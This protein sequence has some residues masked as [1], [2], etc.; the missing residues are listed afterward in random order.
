MAHRAPDGSGMREVWPGFFLGMGRLAIVDR[1]AKNVSPYSF[2]TKTI[3]FNGEIYNH[4]ALRSEL[5]KDFSFETRTDT[6]VFL[7]G[8]VAWGPRVL[9]RVNGMFAVAIADSSE[10]TVFL[11]RDLAGEKPLYY[12]ESPFCFASEAKALGFENLREGKTKEVPPGT[13]LL[14]RP[15]GGCETH[16]WFFP[17]RVPGI[18]REN[19]AELLETILE[20]AVRI[21][22]PAEVPYALY[23]SGGVDSTL[24]STFLADDVPTITWI[25]GDC[26]EEFLDV[27]PKILWHLDKP[28][29]SFS[30]FGLW[31][32]AAEAKKRGVK[33][34]LSGEGADELFGGYVRNVKNEF[35][36]AAAQ[37]FPSYGEMFPHSKD[38]LMDEFR[39]NMRDLLRMGD[40]MAAAFGIENRCPFLDRRIVEF[41]WSL[42]MDMKINWKTLTT[43]VVLRKILEK[44]FP[45]YEDREKEGLFCSVNEWIGSQETFSKKDYMAYQE[46]LWHRFS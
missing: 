17:R 19:A 35:N 39:G 30:P 2:G 3:S 37:K 7:K 25:D 24:I 38:V 5:S 43:K 40:R 27:F 18:T 44:R 42:P 12:L 16:P 15:G 6:E 31:K 46:K 33:V 41:A 28:I 36:K 10:K 32:L 29:S 13:Y 14:W 20:D 9:D 1:Q 11:A 8:Y 26:R 4:D 34:V 21:R 45:T 23:F 22:I